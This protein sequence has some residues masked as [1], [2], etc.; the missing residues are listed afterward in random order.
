MTIEKHPTI[1]IRPIVASDAWFISSVSLRL[2]PA[3]S[4][5]PRNAEQFRAYY[6]QLSPESLLS[7]PGSL[8]FVSELDGVVSGVISAHLDV[9]YFTKHP[10]LY[11]DTLAVADAAE[12]RGVGRALMAFIEGKG[13]EL[14][15][16][17]VVLDVF[18]N[19][20]RA[21]MFY[22]RC[23]YTADHVRMAKPLDTE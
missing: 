11:I 7:A 12:G 23:G 19:N 17:E 15:C 13:R 1:R 4:A 14:G 2:L 20:E 6:E 22:E 16:R 18:A 5:S 9:D 3:H 21:R 10:R 8:A